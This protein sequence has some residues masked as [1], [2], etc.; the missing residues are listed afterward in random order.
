MTIEPWLDDP[1]DQFAVWF[2]QATASEPRDA[3]AMSLG[4]VD[5]DGIVSVR[6]VL[7]KG[8]DHAGF[9]FYTNTLS[10]KGRALA[11]NPRAG[12]CFYWRSTAK[13]VR[14]DGAVSPVSPAEANEYYNSRPRGSRIGAWASLQ[15]QVLDDRSTL[16]G[17]VADFNAQYGA[18]DSNGTV[19]R[20]PHWSGYRVAPE[21]IEF[22]REMPFR[23]HERRV[24]TPRKENLGDGAG[25]DIV[26]LYP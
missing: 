20:P 1:F 25:W 6:T 26:H 4:T 23:L 2:D 15:S 10:A 8:Y 9:V 7:L 5:A 13:Q 18:E 17:R 14:I 12:L 19:P 11:A 22:W 3:N 16:E 24:F 21:R